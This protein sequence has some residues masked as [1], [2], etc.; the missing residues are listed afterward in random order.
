MREGMGGYSVPGTNEPDKLI[1]GHAIPILVE[2]VKLKGGQ[3]ILLRGS[4]IGI[5]TATGKGIL[6]DANAVDGSKTALFVLA[7]SSID[8]T[9]GDVTA[10][11]YKTGTFQRTALIVGVNGAPTTLDSDL[12]TVGI[13]LQDEVA[14]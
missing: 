13:F 6:C 9:S 1:A 7:E 10:T 8:T 12:R 3:G 14:Y 4:V 2:G 11:H 5:E